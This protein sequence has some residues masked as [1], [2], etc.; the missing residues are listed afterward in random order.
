[1][2]AWLTCVDVQPLPAA[3]GA[4]RSRDGRRVGG[5]RAASSSAGTSTSSRR[6]GT[7]SMIDVAGPDQA[8]R[9]AGRGLRRDVQHDGAVGGAAHPAVADAD[10]VAH[11]LL[12]AAWSAAA[13]WPPPACRGSPSARSRAA[14]APSRRRR[15]GPDRRCGRASPRSSRRRPPGRGACSSCRRRG[16]RLDH[17]TVRARGCRAARRCRR[18]PAAASARGRMTS[19]SQIRASSR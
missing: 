5:S 2:S 4:R 10:H 16:G 9:P 1:M 13:C 19:G 12:R 14:P 11:A 17:R 7:S 6:P 15:R 3:A 18:R 8:E